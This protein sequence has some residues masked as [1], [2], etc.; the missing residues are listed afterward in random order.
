M[1]KETIDYATCND[2]LSAACIVTRTQ[3]YNSM[4]PGYYASA[5]VRHTMIECTFYVREVIAGTF[6]QTTV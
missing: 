6:A 4:F 5:R 1:K 3:K 2:N